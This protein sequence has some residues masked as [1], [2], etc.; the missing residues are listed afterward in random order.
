M[1]HD[2]VLATLSKLYQSSLRYLNVTP[3]IH[4]PSLLMIITVAA[5]LGYLDVYGSWT[6]V[7][8]PSRAVPLW[9]MT[10]VL[11]SWLYNY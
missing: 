8:M 7:S 3:I 4:L 9:N 2:A 11:T 10:V 1:H 6:A 5:V